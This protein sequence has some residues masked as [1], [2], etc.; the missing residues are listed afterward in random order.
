MP[1]YSST[2][3]QVLLTAKRSDTSEDQELPKDWDFPL[4]P[5]GGHAGQHRG[6]RASESTRVRTS[7]STHV[8]L[9][10]AATPSPGLLVRML[11]LVKGLEQG[12]DEALNPMPG[13]QGVFN[14]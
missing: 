5:L 7:D 1:I 12:A 2:H 6:Q 11:M 8:S 3:G 9:G 13:A 14:L 10:D 4:L